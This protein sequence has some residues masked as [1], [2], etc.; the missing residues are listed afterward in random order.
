MSLFAAEL[1]SVWPKSAMDQHQ[2]RIAFAS[3]PFAE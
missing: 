3:A 1:F 2:R